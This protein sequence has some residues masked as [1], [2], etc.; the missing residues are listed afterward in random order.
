PEDLLWVKDPETHE[1]VRVNPGEL[2][3]RNVRVGNHIAISPGA[4][5]RFMSRFEEVFGRL[6]KSETILAAASAHHRLAWIHPFVDGNG[7]VARLISHATLLEALDTGAVWSIARGLAR[8]VD[9]YKRHLSA[10]D[11]TRRNDL[12]GRGHLSEETRT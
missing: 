1:R 6:S 8:S 9:A 4:V 3:R 5:P 12:D 10:C 7:R 11:L 2:R